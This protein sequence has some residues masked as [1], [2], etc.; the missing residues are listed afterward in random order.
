VTTLRIGSTGPAVLALQR[1]LLAAGHNPR[2]L[3]ADYGLLTAAAVAGYQRAH[4]PLDVDGVAGPA[5]LGALGLA[6]AGPESAPPTLPTGAYLTPLDALSPP[7]WLPLAP[8]TAIT[9]EPLRDARTGLY[10]RLSYRSALAAARAAGASLPTPDDIEALHALASQGRAVEL[11]PVTLPTPAMVRATGYEGPAVGEDYADAAQRMRVASMRSEAWCRL[12]DDTVATALAAARWDGGRPVA[13]AGKHWVAGAPSGRAYLMGWWQGGKW[14]QPRPPVG[15]RGF[16][17]DLY[18]DYATTT[19]LVRRSPTASRD[20]WDPLAVPLPSPHYSP[21]RPSGPARVLVIHTTENA[22]RA[23]VARAVASYFARPSTPASAHYVVGPD[24]L[25]QCVSD[26][27]RAWHVGAPANAYTIGVEQ[28]GLARYT[29]AE[30]ATPDA[31]AMLDRVVALLAR[32]CRRHAIPAVLLSPEDV[33]EGRAGIATHAA[34]GR[35]VGGTN[36]YDPGAGYPLAS[37]VQRVAALL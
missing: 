26:L 27:D 28:V 11:P 10:A 16:H 29:A 35:G 30:W 8:G 6:G 24:A 1:A 4:P 25:F 15:A 12:H 22:L 34:I 13:G 7:A 5:T 9:A 31:L 2:G 21:G 20:G 32:L 37:V 17:D 36:H 14:I 33:R 18:T 23:G 3:D 19:L